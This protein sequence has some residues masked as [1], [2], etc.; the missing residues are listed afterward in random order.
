MENLMTP[1]TPTSTP[2]I[3]PP[4][5]TWDRNPNYLEEER[6]RREATLSHQTPPQV[7]KPSFIKVQEQDR[8]YHFPHGKVTLMGI[9]SINVSKSGTHRINT[10][11]GKKHIIPPGWL[12]IEFN[13]PEWTF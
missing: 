2:P 12:H 5:H 3:N 13:A 4:Q 6:M 11:D 1:P 8:T 10:I 7:A 9:D